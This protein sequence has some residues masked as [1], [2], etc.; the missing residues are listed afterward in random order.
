MVR[1]HDEW[2]DVEHGEKVIGLGIKS[3]LKIF[4]GT[5]KTLVCTLDS[6]GR[7]VPFLR[8]FSMAQVFH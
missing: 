4:M 1:V 7:Y 2:R 5:K 3:T 6:T 8:T